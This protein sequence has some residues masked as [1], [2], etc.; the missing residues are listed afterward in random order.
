[1]AYD[2]DNIFAKILRG[3]IP[4]KTVYEDDFALAFHDIHPQAPVHVL[5]IP[6]KHVESLDAAG[7]EDAQLLGRLLLAAREVAAGEGIS[8][9]YRVVNNCGESAGQSVFHVHLHVLGGRALG[10]PP[11]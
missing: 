6:R 10:W 4:C 8:G 1:M 2:S 5:V 9:G 11:G 7:A 3:E